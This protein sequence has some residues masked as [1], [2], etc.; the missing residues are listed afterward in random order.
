MAPQ[1][2]L[3]DELE[4]AVRNNDLPRMRELV[5]NDHVDPEAPEFHDWPLL[6]ICADAGY[7]EMSDFL[8][9]EAS[10]DLYARDEDGYTALEWAFKHASQ[11]HPERRVVARNIEDGRKRQK[12][13][14][15]NP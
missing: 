8:I 6:H 4:K 14:P 7:V 15:L 11:E 10:V 12:G 9:N 1:Q 3:K 5:L 13:L 2:N